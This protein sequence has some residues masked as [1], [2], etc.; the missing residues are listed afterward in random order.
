MIFD[1][2][3]FFLQPFTVSHLGL[4][5]GIMVT[6]SHNPKQDNGYKVTHFTT[7]HLPSLFFF[8]FFGKS[9]PGSGPDSC[10]KVFKNSTNS[11]P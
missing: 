3:S 8:F 6:A 11:A 1:C 2:I 7:S 9:F 4:C 10:M 5:A